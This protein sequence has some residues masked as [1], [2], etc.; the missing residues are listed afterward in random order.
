MTTLTITRG[1]PGSGKT[2]W[3]KQQQTADP[4]LWRVNRDGLRAMVLPRW[5]YG[6]T[7]S[8]DLLTEIQ[9]SAVEVLLDRGH[10]VIIDDTNLRPDV[11]ESWRCLAAAYEVDF[12]IVDFTDILLVT[13]IERDAARP[14]AERVGEQV[15]RGMWQ[16]YLA[17]ERGQ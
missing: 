2:T 3:A 8:E 13:C 10:D 7:T 15:I 16:K 14:K 12:R 1:L 9:R 11:V 5:I 6:S 17:P 4:N